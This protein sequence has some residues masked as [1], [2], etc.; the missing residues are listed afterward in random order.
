M[1][2]PV[3]IL[4]LFSAVCSLAQENTTPDFIWGQAS[5]YN[6]EVGDEIFFNGNKVTFIQNIGNHSQFKVENDTI[7]LKVA[8]R[9][10]PHMIN[11]LNIYVAD[12]FNLKKLD[13]ESGVHGLLTKDVLVCLT[14]NGEMLM[15]SKSASFP[16]AFNDG[17]IWSGEEDS[18]VFAFLKKQGTSNYYSYPGIGLDMTDARGLEK[19][20]IIA[21]ED[22]TVEWIEENEDQNTSCV[23]LKSKNNENLYYVYDG[24]YRKNIQVK[25]DQ[26]L[27]YGELIGTAWGD[28]NWGNVKIA[29]VY[30][31]QTPEYIN[32]FN[33][34]INFFPQLYQLYYNQIYG[35]SRSFSKGKISFGRAP[36]YNQNVQ[37]VSCFE[38]FFGKGWLLDKNNIAARVEWLTNGE[39]GN[40]RLSKT[41]FKGSK[42]AYTNPKDFYCYE[43]NV[44]N[45]V[46]RIRAKVGDIEKKSWQKVSFED[47]ETKSFALEAGAQEWTSEKVVRVN[48]H[49]LS[50]RVYFDT[51]GDKVAGLSELVFQQAY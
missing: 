35:I 40:V 8:Q 24:L 34:V 15:D 16:V 44:P 3:L 41:L 2:K 17:Y 27:I 11:A 26:E 13:S 42:A 14:K 51:S 9:S 30:S 12:N 38:E 33:N 23:L 31:E 5:Y 20:W 6:M 4:L 22:C 25:K 37:N 45:G 1:I 18:Y 50:I 21:I 36:M 46:Y 7:L 32:R 10:L 29:V 43:I 49:R 47:V 28:E 48:D 39:E 19:H